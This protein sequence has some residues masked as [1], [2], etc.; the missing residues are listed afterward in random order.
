MKPT[1]KAVNPPPSEPIK[2]FTVFPKL[3]LE[4]RDMIWDL[5]VPA[6]QV[7]SIK[8][9]GA[10]QNPCWYYDFQTV[11]SSAF[12]AVASY[13]IPAVLHANQESRI[14]GKKVLKSAFKDQL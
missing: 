9:V 3:P 5:A 14:R 11:F 7:I 13:K 8:N 10:V 1:K 2:E 4:I 6:Q 12:K